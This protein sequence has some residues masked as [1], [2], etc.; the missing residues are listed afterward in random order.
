MTSSSLIRWCGR[1]IRASFILLFLT[2]PL[3]LTPWN[4]ELFE[5][6]KMMVTYALT[7]VIAAAWIVKMAAK[8]EF[9]VARTPLDIPIALFFLSQLVATVFSMDPHV[10]W[11]GYYSRFNGGLW[12]VISYI[13]LYYAFVSNSEPMSGRAEERE[14]GRKSNQLSSSL[15]P[16]LF[17]TSYLPLL[18]VMLV[19]A[20][21]VASYGA[22][23]HFGIDKNLWVQDVQNRVFSTLGQ[24]NWLAAYLVAL[25]P[26]AMASAIKITHPGSQITRIDRFLHPDAKNKKE[27]LNISGLEPRSSEFG[28][29]AGL[30]LWTALSALFF[31]VL[32]WTRSRSGLLGA[33]VADAAFW[34]ILFL[35]SDLRKRLAMPFIF[36]HV[37]FALIV[38]VNGT[39]VE[40][41]DRYVTL[42]S[43]E[44][45][46]HTLLARVPSTATAS[47][48]RS[49]GGSSSQQSAPPPGGTMLETGGTESSTI[50]KYV[51][52]GALRAWKSTPKTLL[53]GTGT[54]TF[55][56]AFYRFRPKEHNLTSEWDFLYNKAH[57]EYLNYLAT[58]GA[59][60]L[61][62]YL[63]L[64][65][66][67][68]GWFIKAQKIQHS[69]VEPELSFERRIVSF[70]LFS[71]WLSIL[72][73]NFFGF[74]V[75]IIQLLFFL[76]P[77]M[78]ITLLADRGGP[79]RSI[80]FSPK[81]AGAVIG[82][83]TALGVF[84]LFT[85][86]KLWYADVLFALGYRDNRENNFQAAAP[87]IR[88]AVVLNANEPFYHDEYATTLAG[89][90]LAAVNEKNAT[91]AGEL[92]KESL[93]QSDTALT[94]SPQNVNYW[95][96]RTKI[97]YSF[98]QFDPAFNGD[99]I[100]A[101]VHAETLSP[102][103]PKIL[104]NLAILYGRQNDN[105]KAIELLKK[106]IVLK[107]DYRD[108][109]YALFVFYRDMKKTA[110][111]KATLEQYL[112]L[113]DP[114]DREFIRLMAQ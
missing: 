4:Y 26:L 96:T 64:L 39:Y 36:F 38:F 67:F 13:V 30:V 48:D 91:A 70:A 56:F 62:S 75:V 45:R 112:T 10:S 79:Y 1:I 77:A 86:G 65:C 5:F 31:L 7:V 27:G 14:T 44:N 3:I 114:N 51:W 52:E 72:V 98:S 15:H 111:A 12:S 47:A 40:T 32:L 110:D 34:G 20:A 17:P 80:R 83:G 100:Q 63:L 19:T 43:W 76:I 97:F 28:R 93:M 66:V 107:A 74:S 35:N 22:L 103:D 99:A 2:V 105:T 6:N 59:F 88:Q 90:T 85:V 8:R 55:A 104:Y 33:A 49:P 69:D 87:L 109:Y 21:V 78:V 50:R 95:K 81:L 54:E 68:I 101:L 9:F 92:A 11:F 73:T 61:G 106:A 41:I 82:T 94:I 24:P 18:K 23:E 60:G 57:N 89:L 16:P 113:V 46:V 84:L 53:V 29:T 108:A 58:T 71:G 102:N 42:G 37:L 25:L